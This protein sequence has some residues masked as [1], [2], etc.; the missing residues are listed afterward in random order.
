MAHVTIEE[1]FRTQLDLSGNELI[2][3]SLIY[4]F[5]QQKNGVFYGSRAFIQFWLGCKSL[6][7]VDTTIASLVKRGLIEKSEYYEGAVRRCAYRI[8]C[9]PCNFCTGAKSAQQPVQNLPETGANSAHNSSIETTTDSPISSH[10]SR[11]KKD[12]VKIHFA[13]FVTMTEEEHQKLVDEFG[14]ADTAALI[15]ILDNYKGS[16]DVKYKSDYRAIRS[17]CVDRLEEHK[18]KT[19]QRFGYQQP[20]VIGPRVNERGETPT[21]ASMRAAAESFGRI[22]ARHA[23]APA[24]VDVIPAPVDEQDQI[25]D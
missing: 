22:A 11:A 25:D 10:T 4:G 8:T 21:V 17:W 16:K 6:R 19:S 23:A 3:Y 24:G 12:E 18:R 20:P 15:Q 2:V 5:S 7:T 13:E 1:A 14:E 9:D